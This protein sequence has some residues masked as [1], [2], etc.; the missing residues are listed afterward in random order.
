MGTSNSRSAIREAP[1]GKVCFEA[2]YILERSLIYFKDFS[3]NNVTI[4]VLK[5]QQKLEGLF[6][7]K[8]FGNVLKI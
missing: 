4:S 3:A 2:V 8:I 6:S 1:T 7:I 5:N